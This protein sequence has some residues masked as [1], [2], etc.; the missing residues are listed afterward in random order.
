MRSQR[1]T[2][3]DLVTL[4]NPGVRSQQVVW[5]NN[6]TTPPVDLTASYQEAATRKETSP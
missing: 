5:P 3:D 6:A 1:L 4:Q 2:A